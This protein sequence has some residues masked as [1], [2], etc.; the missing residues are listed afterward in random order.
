MKEI[1]FEESASVPE[2]NTLGEAWA[3]IWNNPRRIFTNWNYKAAL[4][5]GMLRAPIF[6]GTYLLEK[7]SLKIALGAASAQF[8]YRFLFAGIFGSLIQAFRRVEP[9]WK[10]IVT[11][12][13][14]IPALSHVIEFLVQHSY[15]YFTSTTGHTEKAIIGSICVSI[16]S[17]LFNLFAMRRDVM[18]VGEAESK[19]IWGDIKHIPIV[20][21]EFIAFIPM[22]VTKMMR[23]GAWLS[24]LLI[25]FG[26]GV[27]SQLMC[28][29]IFN[30]P[31]WTYSQGKSNFATIW[32][33]DGIIL[34]LLAT[35]ICA[36]VSK[37][38][39]LF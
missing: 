26:F 21:F 19:T 10:S 38:R 29:A 23:R 39:K 4:L 9:A 11:I 30:K 31:Y 15:A 1:T 33:V 22:K 3:S 28:W 25:V 34:L 20:A 24:A 18:I 12:M 13:L 32:G 5:S 36:F 8:V 6:F 16:I 7:E 37:R 27:F 14:V 35:G 2:T 17:A